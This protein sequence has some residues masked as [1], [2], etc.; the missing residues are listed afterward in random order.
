MLGLGDGAEFI[1]HNVKVSKYRRRSAPMTG[2]D[3]RKHDVGLRPSYPQLRNLN[4]TL[5]PT[6]PLRVARPFTVDSGIVHLSETLCVQILS[7]AVG[8]LVVL[9]RD[10]RKPSLQKDLAAIFAGHEIGFRKQHQVWPN[11]FVEVHANSRYR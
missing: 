8:I 7:R 4:V 9:K 10:D 6:T 11:E 2:Y 3:M 5:E 1:G